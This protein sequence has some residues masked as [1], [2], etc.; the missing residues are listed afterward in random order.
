MVWGDSLSLI[1]VLQSHQF[2]SFLSCDLCRHLNLRF[3]TIIK[4]L[5]STPKVQLDCSCSDIQIATPARKLSWPIYQ[6]F[7]HNSEISKIIF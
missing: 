3:L 4:I 7:V 6:F 1:T 5:E 2:V